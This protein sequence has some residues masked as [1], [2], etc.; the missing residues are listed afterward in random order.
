MAAVVCELFSRD[1]PDGVIALTAL[2]PRLA[3]AD[4][5]G[6]ASRGGVEAPIDIAALN[7]AYS[8]GRPPSV[9]AR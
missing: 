1:D 9:M 3:D 5:R 7:A 8:G 2:V 6:C 4:R